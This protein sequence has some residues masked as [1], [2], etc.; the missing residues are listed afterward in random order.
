M[1]WPLSCS[2]M[3]MIRCPLV[4]GVWSGTPGDARPG[5]VVGSMT[6]L[7]SGL[8]APAGRGPT[9]PHEVSIQTATIA[10]A[11]ITLR[12]RITTPQN[13]SGNIPCCVW[14]NVEGEPPH[15]WCGAMTCR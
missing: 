12:I 9:A 4:G 6:G 5:A 2:V 13:G 3:T 1:E 15:L 14:G 10:T 11:Q 7:V 8:D